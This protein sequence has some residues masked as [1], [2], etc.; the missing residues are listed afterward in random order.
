MNTRFAAI[1]SGLVLMAAV[2]ADEPPAKPKS[3]E[4]APSQVAV[5]A[6]NTVATLDRAYGPDEK[7]K[8]DIYAPK[9]AKGLPVVIYIHGGEWTKGDKADVSTKPKFFNENG[10]VMVS[11]N[12]RLSPA[13]K[14]PAH[15]SDLASALRWTV[16]HIAEL[17]GDP[18]KIVVMGHS[19][20]C[21]LVVLTMIDPQYLAKVNLKAT[22]LRAIV[23]WSGGAFDLVHKAKSDPK[24]LEYIRN[25]F[26]PDEQSWYDA[27]PMN[28]TK[29]AKANPPYLF[30]T[31]DPEGDSFRIVKQL[32]KGIQDA[33]GRAST[34]V[35]RD[36]THRTA[37]HLLGS[38][39][40]TTGTQLLEFLRA[41]TK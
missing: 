15:V 25:A 32:M 7:Q 12:Y 40:D 27:S 38:P 6:S 31:A 13:V 14:H 17:G 39:G 28:L 8:L 29:N 36:R 22:D 5:L 34:L 21:H 20:G 33:G 3:T 35:L 1:V 4:P 23:A 24:Y 30:V 10:F 37:N 2:R 16:D 41:N 26:G 19:A 18:K 11:A 9:D